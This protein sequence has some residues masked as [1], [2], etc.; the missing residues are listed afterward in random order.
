VPGGLV[1]DRVG[2]RISPVAEPGDDLGERQRGAFGVGEAGCIPPG[3]QCKEALVRFACLLE[4]VEI[5]L[6]ADPACLGQID[7]EILD[8]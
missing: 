1:P 3:R 7:L 5:E 4:I 2:Y 6:L 8:G